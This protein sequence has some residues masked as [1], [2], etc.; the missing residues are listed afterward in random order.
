MTFTVGQIV[1]FIVGIVGFCLTILNIADKVIAMKDR[2]Q[3][4]FKELTDKVDAIDVKVKSIEDSLLKHGEQMSEQERA[5][6]VMQTCML[7]LIDYELANCIKTG[8]D[9]DGLTEARDTLRQYLVE[10]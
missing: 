1:A 9:T 6:E 10:G 5:S 7:A 2:A 4:P 3:E 8:K